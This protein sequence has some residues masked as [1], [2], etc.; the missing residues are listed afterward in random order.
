MS[1]LIVPE[2]RPVKVHQPQTVTTLTP[3]EMLSVAV[4]QGRDLEYVEK[5]MDLQSRWEAEE[6]RKSYS[7][8]MAAAQA[9]ITVVRK[10]RINPH[11]NSRYADISAVYE[12]IVPV[13]TKHGFS[14]SFQAEPALEGFLR[15]IG[16]C[17]HEAGH[18]RSFP[19]DVP[20]DS[21]GSGGKVN[22]TVVQAS[23]STITYARRYLTLMIFNVATSDDVDGNGAGG[24]VDQEALGKAIDG[25]LAAD[26]DGLR[27]AVKQAWEKFGDPSS[28]KAITAAKDQRV[29]EIQNGTA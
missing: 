6:A 17:Q 7:R 14:L 26:K 10:N 12:A 9:E 28:R 11:T 4:S 2:D 13:I 25:I 3:A 22:K 18:S 23:G 16:T 20:L 24:N 8:A 5:L 27:L 29:K 15:I 21:A 1:K 19:L